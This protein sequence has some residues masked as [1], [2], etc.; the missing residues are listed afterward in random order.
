[1]DFPT[2]DWLATLDPER[3]TQHKLDAILDR[4]GQRDFRAAQDQLAELEGA[5]GC[6]TETLLLRYE[7]EWAR[8]RWED[9]LPCAEQLRALHPKNAGS[10]C[11]LVQSYIGLGR[12]SEGHQVLKAASDEE[13]SAHF[14][15]LALGD[16]P[17]LE[18]VA[19]FSAAE[20]D[21]LGNPVL[22]SDNA[23]SALLQSTL[24]SPIE[25]AGVARVIG[26]YFPDKLAYTEG[27]F[28]PLRLE[29]SRRRT[30]ILIPGRLRTFELYRE[31][32]QALAQV[33]DIFACVDGADEADLEFLRS[34]GV[35][36][37]TYEG[38]EKLANE[39]KFISNGQLHQW[40]KYQKCID[41]LLESEARAGLR[42]EY[43]LK[44]R[45]DHVIAYDEGFTF[46]QQGRP[47]LVG[48]ND[49]LFYGP[50]DVMVTL[51]GIYH[52]ALVECLGRA[53]NEYWKIRWDLA[54]T[55]PPIWWSGFPT[56]VVGHPTTQ[57]ELLDS[58]ISKRDLLSIYE[59][60]SDETL[61]SVLDI[62]RGKPHDSRGVPEVW[63]A[64]F[65]NMHDIVY[66]EAQTLFGALV[67]QRK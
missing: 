4:I 9:T 23:L 14:N 21:R 64:R 47:R 6:S 55:Y 8:G 59:Q 16:L 49:M 52:F 11:R 60:K 46:E 27:M 18:L 5:I 1:M 15:R 24:L 35:R 7:L 19:I 26:H 56:S 29:C 53:E 54:R 42:Y 38:D 67:S 25:K 20:R 2:R 45:T 57:E 50:R 37:V 3:Q 12:F 36:V 41:L 32:V 48:L 61:I 30:A 22:C 17:Y 66:E 51:R 58:A 63:M 33:A 34:R 10:C 43:V 28:A 39:A 31:F 13:R 44:C 65:L 40:L 62:L